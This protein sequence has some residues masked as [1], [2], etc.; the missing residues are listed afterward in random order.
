MEIAAGLVH[1]ATQ[2]Q[3]AEGATSTATATDA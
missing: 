3:P 1:A 2:E